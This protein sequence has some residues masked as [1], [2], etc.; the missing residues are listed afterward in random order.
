M[1]SIESRWTDPTPLRLGSA[2]GLKSR[3]AA[4]GR[5]E[6]ILVDFMFCCCMRR[7]PSL[8]A[9]DLAKCLVT[10]DLARPGQDSKWD[11]STALRK[12]ERTGLNMQAWRNVARSCL[13]PMCWMAPRAKFWEVGSARSDFGVNGTFQRP[14]DVFWWPKMTHFPSLMI[15]TLNLVNR[16]TQS[17]SHSWPM[18][19]REPE[20]RPSKMWPTWAFW[21]APLRAEARLAL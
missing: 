7:C 15:L 2:A 6:A 21:I 19:M 18:E 5:S 13:V 20:V 11:L 10:S 1:E 14:S 16:A 8:V 12:V 3:E 4:I 17:S 9:S